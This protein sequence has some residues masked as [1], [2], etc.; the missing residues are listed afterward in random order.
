M[1]GLELDA[2]P[3]VVVK[4]RWRDVYAG[5]RVL[6]HGNVLMVI[7]SIEMGRAQLKVRFRR[8]GH[9]MT[10]EVDPDGDAPVLHDDPDHPRARPRIREC[11]T[12]S[13]RGKVHRSA[14]A[15]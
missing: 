5:D 12:C 1:S 11:K 15:A 9:V 8:G 4:I 7:E 13:G 6:G 10:Q 3:Q 14:G 2:V